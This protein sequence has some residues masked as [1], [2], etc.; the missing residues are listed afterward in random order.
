MIG[1]V[2]VRYL[3]TYNEYDP[4]YYLFEIKKYSNGNNIQ[5]DYKEIKIDNNQGVQF[6]LNRQFSFDKTFYLQ[7]GDLIY[8]QFYTLNVTERKSFRLE[9]VDINFYKIPTGNL[10][11]L[12]IGNMYL[13]TFEAVKTGSEYYPIGASNDILDS[14]AY[15][16][17]KLT[18]M[19]LML[20]PITDE[21][22]N[23]VE[24]MQVNNPYENGIINYYFFC[25]QYWKLRDSIYNEIN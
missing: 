10:F 8:F 19:D 14:A 24:H 22:F 18:E 16:A 23:I 15:N 11:P 21:M 3:S 25:N 17:P 4:L 5:L 7:E 6:G 2:K 20:Y 13:P 1:D 12:I 9:N